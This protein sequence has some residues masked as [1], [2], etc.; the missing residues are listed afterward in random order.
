MSVAEKV[1]DLNAI[2]ESFARAEKLAEE[3]ISLRN[4]VI[5]LSK[6][7][8]L[9]REGWRAIQKMEPGKP[10]W[11]SLGT[12]NHSCFR[13]F[14]FNHLDPF[15]KFDKQEAEDFLRADM[16]KLDEEITKARN[17]LR[18]ATIDLERLRGHKTMEGM[19][20][21]PFSSAEIQDLLQKTDPSKV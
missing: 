19:E 10:V 1:D 7:K 11:L 18:K 15:V 13:C 12:V 14:D 2:K 6:K 3:V 8:E 9:S 16:K 4:E 20:L 21:V 17:S 5:G